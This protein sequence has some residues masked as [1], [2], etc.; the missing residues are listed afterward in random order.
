[1]AKVKNTANGSA[2]YFEAP[3][4]AAGDHVDPSEFKPA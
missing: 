2:L 4:W 3:L 1:M